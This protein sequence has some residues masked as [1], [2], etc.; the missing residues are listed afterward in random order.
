MSAE[1]AERGPDALERAAPS[2][3]RALARFD[4][5]EAPMS[6]LFVTATK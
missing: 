3:E 5:Q 2:A 6:A 4:G 1:I